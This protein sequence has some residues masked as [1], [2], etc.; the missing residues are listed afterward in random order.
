MTEHGHH[1]NA[2]ANRLQYLTQ[3]IA[4]LYANVQTFF[5]RGVEA[6]R[7]IPEQ[8]PP[9]RADLIAVLRSDASTGAFSTLAAR[10]AD[11]AAAKIAVRIR[12]RN[13]VAVLRSH[14]N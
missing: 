3:L 10:V 5:G 12:Y 13:T 1:A 7:G 8:S 9:R 4:S 11:K 14:E 6:R 2:Y